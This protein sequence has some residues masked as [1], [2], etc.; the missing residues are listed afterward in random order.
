M[1]AVFGAKS[2]FLLGSN[3]LF[4]T[5]LLCSE[6]EMAKKKILI[7]QPSHYLSKA[8]RTVFKSRSRALVPLALPYLASLTPPDWEVTL[9]DEQVQD[10]SYETRPDLVAI[11]TWTVHSLRAYD[12]AAEFRNRGIPVIMGGPH[13]WFHPE[14]AAKHCDAIG[15]GEAEPIWPQMLADASAGKLEKIYRAPQ[16]TSIASLP[17]P[18][19]HKL[20]LSRYGHF[21]TFSL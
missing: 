8:D 21:K 4:R 20:D 3:S 2:R 17:I 19:W 9:V 16:M 6:K 14:E 11:T 1:L 10:F 12:I 15:I 5:R 7:I 18:H 13:I